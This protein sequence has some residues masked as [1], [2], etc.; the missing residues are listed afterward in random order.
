[1]DRFLTSAKR[2]P[3]ELRSLVLK[4]AIE[5][6]VLREDIRGLLGLTLV[7]RHWHQKC[8]PAIYRTMTLRNT[9]DVSHVPRPGDIRSISLSK[10]NIDKMIVKAYRS[11][12]PYSH[13]E[14]QFLSLEFLLVCIQSRHLPSLTSMVFKKKLYHGQA[15]LLP[16]RIDRALPALLRP[17]KSITSLSISERTF[18]SFLELSRVI[19]ALR[20]LCRLDLESVASKAHR[21]T[22][23]SVGRTEEHKWR[24]QITHISYMR[25]RR[26]CYAV[27][28]LSHILQAQHLITPE[29]PPF[30]PFNAEDA[31]QL[32]SLFQFS[33]DEIYFVTVNTTCTD[34]E[35]YHIL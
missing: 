18:H 22:N 14:K 21:I 25:L 4:F 35:L 20:M 24:T 5:D 16:P 19:T 12:Y 7:C 28:L 1:M 30:R 31:R 10:I 27:E 29:K 8:S 15:S 2:L 34:C 3:P 32:A 6:S 9:R 11:F 13:D 23:P 26:D 17:W 33:Y